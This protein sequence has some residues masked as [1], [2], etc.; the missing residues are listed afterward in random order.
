M[1][2][3][4]D[5]WY[6]HHA[7][8]PAA[9]TACGAFDLVRLHRF[10]DLDPAELDMPLNRR[11]SYAAMVGLA[12][13]DQRATTEMERESSER[14][15]AEIREAFGAPD[16]DELAE[17][18]GEP[19]DRPTLNAWLGRLSRNARDSSI[20][21][22]VQNWDLMMKH[23]PVL[24]SLWF[25]EM[26]SNIHID[27]MPDKRTA[28]GGVLNKAAQDSVRSYLER[29][30]SGFKPSS[31]RLEQMINDHALK[32]TRNPRR[33]W[34]LSLP[35]WDGTPRVETAMPG[36]EPTTYTRTVLRKALVAAVARVLDPGCKWDHVP[37]LQGDEGLLKTSWI[38]RISFDQAD[39]LGSIDSKDTFLDMQESWFLILDETGRTMRHTD[40]DKLKNFVTR[41]T[42]KYRA[43]YDKHPVR[44]PRMCVFWGTTNDPEF[45]KDTA[46]N[47]RYWPLKVTEKFDPN[48]LTDDFV[49]QVWAEALHL[50]RAGEQLFLDDQESALAAEA[51][52]EHTEDLMS[53]G[54]IL[55]LLDDDGA[56]FTC[57][58][59][60]WDLLYPRGH[61]VQP[62]RQRKD[63]NDIADVLRKSGE[64]RKEATPRRSPDDGLQSYGP[65]RWW[66]RIKPVNAGLSLEDLL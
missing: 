22:T 3:R 57:A 29:T 43:P 18:L 21:D 2:D 54:E 6:S 49:T 7:N 42:D 31:A 37:V 9:H 41:R 14:I 56:N 45:L 8:D 44:H 55:Q 16:D 17:L 48:L 15:A 66:V 60:V 59:H 24:K 10:G 25:N 40:H 36:V 13:G 53:Y 65:Q 32:R 46:G 4:P 34:L 23:D 62:K 39:T 27:R 35:A 1:S 19:V 50:H 33:E 61:G 20:R 28:P 47:R 52:E 12:E 26:S 51:R 64:W 38:E 11:P 5:L 63:E 30:Y 58:K